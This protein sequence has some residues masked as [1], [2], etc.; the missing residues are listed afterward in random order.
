MSCANGAVV[1]NV[2]LNKRWSKASHPAYK[3]FTPT[4]GDTAQR[5]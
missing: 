2:E 3:V 4:R 5:P 1:V